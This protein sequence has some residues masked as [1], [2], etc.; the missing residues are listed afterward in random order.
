MG[1]LNRANRIVPAAAILACALLSVSG[2]AAELS[3]NEQLLR[4]AKSGSLEQV[5]K[6]LEKGAKVESRDRYDRTLPME[7]AGF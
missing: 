2:I 3:V 1:Y 7:A 5:K 4:A 6:L